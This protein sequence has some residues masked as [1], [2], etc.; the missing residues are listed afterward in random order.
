MSRSDPATLAQAFAALVGQDVEDERIDL[1]RASLTIAQTEYPNLDFDAYC[2]RIEE[3]ARR[4]KRLVPDLGD[5]SESITALNRVLFEEEGFRGN[6][7]DYYD[8]RNSC[9]ND[10]LDRKLGIPITLA[11]V[12]MEVARRVGFP[13]VGVGMPG[14]FLLKHYDVEGREILIDPFNRGSIL[15]AKDCQRALD[16]IY[17]GQMPLQPEFL[18]AVSRR[19][20][21]VRMLNN[22]KS[23]YLSGRNFR[24]A[25]PI[26]DLILAIYPRSPEDVKQRALLRWSLGQTRGALA[27]LEDYLKMSPDASDADEIRQTAASLR[28]MM[29]TM[30]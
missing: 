21:L 5:P 19:Q 30:N 4:V 26:V 23:I 22:L 14:H 24:K 18:M 9:L 25:L 20:V 1:V 27:D 13:L 7:E 15:T 16:E 2:A 17:G 8:P 28:R 29:A 10:V 12:Y 11:V 6:A 3:L